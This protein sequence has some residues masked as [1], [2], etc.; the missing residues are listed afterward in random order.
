MTFPSFFQWKQFFKI[1]NK[2]EKIALF[3]FFVSFIGSAIFLAN[4]LYYDHTKIAPAF[5]GS[6][7]EGLVGQPRFINPIYSEASDI[8]RDIT[9]LIFSGLM[10]YNKEGEIVKDLAEEYK[11][12]EEGRVYE[13]YLKDNI[14]WHD[15]K[16]LT[17]DDIIFT[18]ETI[19]N[20]DYKS[21]LRAN[22]LGVETEK[23]SD[24]AL[25]FRLNTPYSSFLENCT[26]KILPKHIWESI[27]PENFPL[28][29]Y[30]LQPIGSGIYKF[31]GIKQ[32]EDG[33]IESLILEANKKYYKKSPF[34]S[35][36]SLYFFKNEEE[37]IKAFNTKEIDGL[38]LAS[39]ES[40]PL[41]KN[42]YNLYSYL[43]PRYFAVFFNIQKSKLLAEKE[44]REA[45]TYAIDKEEIIEEMGP[46]AALIDSP[47][48]PNFFGYEEAEGIRQFDLEKAKNILEEAGFPENESGVRE[49][50]TEKQPAFQFKS[51]LRTGSQGKEVEELQKCLSNYPDVYPDQKVTGYFGNLTKE[52]VI[53]FQEKYVDEILTPSGLTQGP[54]YVGVKT[55]QKLNELCAPPSREVLSLNFSLTT[56]DQ[57]YL[58]QIGENLKEQWKEA[59]INIDI[60]P[61]SISE[62]K[63]VIKKREYDLLLF[64]EVLGAIPDPFPF[65]HSSQKD[66]PGLNLS[67]YEN[68][69][70]DKL[71]KA[72]R[73]TL[74]ENIREEK[75]E[76][77]QNLIIKDAPA[78]FLYSPNY[79]YAVSERIKGINGQKLINP[80]KRFSNIENWYIQT[81]RVWR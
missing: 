65:W 45:L 23:I 12:L 61:L 50:T 4:S 57:P 20:S 1:L 56:V 55:R 26:V 70:V 40:Y 11:V 53:R 71:L 21:P 33:F 3:L 47:I 25:R 41:L 77:F 24:T 68:E 2:G 28:S 7:K 36:V 48:L 10:S 43:L 16:A 31:Q 5:G 58:I 73:E 52:A 30:N 6:Y 69:D 18:I 8:D 37:L 76:E 14:F 13:F 44:I 67:G 64:G 38:S 59:G 9:E 19:Q 74:D 42:G 80:A 22:W 79:L 62:L 49:K 29:P 27:S 51:T 72:A 32:T 17:T 54:G 81:R 34:I 46:Y 75:F 15:G 63:S 39:P 35:Q 78:L 60:N 66:D